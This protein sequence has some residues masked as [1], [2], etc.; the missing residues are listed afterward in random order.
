MKN[1]MKFA[2]TKAGLVV[3]AA[4]V[5]G[6]VLYVAE[7]KVRDMGQAV[8]PLNNDNIFAAGVD[9]V[10]ANLTGDKNFKLGG[11]IYDVFHSND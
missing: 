11:W 1:L 8:N 10:G 2:D 4:V 5:G 6:V 3:A 9:S 7:K